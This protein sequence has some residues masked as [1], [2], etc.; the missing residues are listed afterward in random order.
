MQPENI[1]FL[2]IGILLFNYFL[3]LFLDILN[4]RNTNKN[5]PPELKDVYKDEEW[6]KAKKYQKVNFNFELIS[7]TFSLVVTLTFIYAGGFG[8]LY[9]TIANYSQHFIV[10]PLLF[11]G[12]LSFASSIIGLPFS[13]YHTFV[14]EEKFGFNK[15]TLK[16]WLLDLLKSSVLGILIGAPLLALFF[17]LILSLESNFWIVFWIIAVAF[18]IF[19]NLFYTSL[20]L[21]IFN[22]LS[23]LEEGELK[24]LIQTYSEQVGF[25]LQKIMVIDGSKRSSKSNAFF[26]GLG[27]TKKVVFYDTLLNNHENGELMAILAHEVGHYKKKHIQI[28]LFLSIIQMGII[29]YILSLFVFSQNISLA[30][31]YQE[32]SIAINLI[33]FGILFSPISKII[34]I[35]FNIFSRK[36]EYEAD[37]FAAKTWN[38][39]D[40]I[41]ALKKLS[42]KNLSNI[43]PHKAFV[44]VNYSHPTLLQRLKALSNSNG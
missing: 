43:Q 39:E 26:S 14:I 22:K 5:L 12:I 28:S 4:I 17:Y 21:P 37:E 13:L 18:S 38:A 1:L 23:P 27:K 35:F 9:D 19:M 36:N 25:P 29:L 7:G 32:V 8:W 24:T 44:F 20:I 16:T 34:G 33:A 6:L 42:V 30:L 41:T 3:D 11:F 15:T 2:I 10:R 40:L 31:G